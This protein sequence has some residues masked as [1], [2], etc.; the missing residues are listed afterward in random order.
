MFKV[1]L[2]THSVASP[3]GSITASQYHRVLKSKL[4]DAIAITDHNRIDFAVDMHRKMGERIIVGEEIMTSAGEII[5]L[6]LQTVIE[7][8]LT[9]LETMKRIKEQNGIV[10]IPHPFETVRKGL[11][12]GVLEELSDH[13]DVMEVCN[14]RAFFQNRSEQAAIW[15]RLNNR[16]GA[17]SSDAH[18][19]A[20]LGDTY[21]SV[22]ALPSRETLLDLLN[23]GV[24]MTSRPSV[25]AL[26]YPKLNRVRKK[27]RRKAS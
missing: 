16:P 5:G 7:P 10:Y 19:H 22:P 25:R 26:L 27:L 13:I 18:G 1:D 8:G 9:P 11:T 15:A 21:T 4:L 14:G 17:A 6:Y 12:S 23:K 3:D 20:G 24:P 2:H